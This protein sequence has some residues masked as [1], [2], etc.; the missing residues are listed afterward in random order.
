[1]KTNVKKC[2]LTLQRN[3]NRFPPIEINGK[4]LEVVDEAKLLGL[5]I[6]SNLKWN[7]HVNNIVLKS[8]NRI[9]LQVQLKRA[10]DI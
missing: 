1:M 4:P 2:G 7:S 10:K 6:T 5:T 8:S 9:Y 3:S